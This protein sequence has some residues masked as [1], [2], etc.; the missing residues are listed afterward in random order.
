MVVYHLCCY[1]QSFVM[2]FIK[3]ETI[4]WIFLNFNS[5]S[6]THYSGYIVILYNFKAWLKITERTFERLCKNACVCLMEQWNIHNTPCIYSM[7][8]Y[9]DTQCT[10]WLLKRYSVDS[11][12][13]GLEIPCCVLL[14]T[15]FCENNLWDF[16]LTTVITELRVHSCI[17][18]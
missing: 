13:G 9:V 5:K 18:K 1:Q 16:N 15:T 10:Q 14:W 11:T 3:N 17:K 4:L 2:L 8:M 12:Q 6:V 7:Y